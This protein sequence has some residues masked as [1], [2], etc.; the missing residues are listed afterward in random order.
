MDDA[1]GVLVEPLAPQHQGQLEPEQLVEGQAAPG[2][3]DLV[4]GGRP[5]DA[6]EGGRAVDEPDAG[7]GRPS[8]SGSANGPARSSASWTSRPMRAEVS[9]AFSVRG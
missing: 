4:H 6:G 1:A 8:S 9:A 2:R 3:L 5:V 7:A